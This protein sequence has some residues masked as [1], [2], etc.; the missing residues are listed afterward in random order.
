MP[1]T[2]ASAKVRHF[3]GPAAFRRWLEA[4]HARSTEL[5]VGFHNKASG[6]GGLSYAEALD[7]ALCFGWIDGVRRK[8]DQDSYTNRFT[9]RK[10]GSIW[11]NV[12]VR[13]AERLVAEGRLRPAGLAAFEAR[14]ASRTGVYSFER[15]PE[16]LPPGLERRLRASAA[17]WAF[18]SV[19][20]PGYRRVATWWVVSAKQ[21]ETRERR[22]ARLLADSAAG[23]RL[24]VVA[25]RARAKG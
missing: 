21:E 25:G 20:P 5:W 11:S 3:P 8:V 9:P 19:Q 14:L 23:R 16:R 18:W 12:N 1:A 24:A 2:S 15:R 7:E 10:R 17:A 4:H 22:L 6:L 13:H